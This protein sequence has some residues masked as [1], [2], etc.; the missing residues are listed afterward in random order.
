MIKPAISIYLV[1]LINEKGEN[2]YPKYKQ[3]LYI[4][5]REINDTIVERELNPELETVTNLS[6]LLHEMNNV[7]WILKNFQNCIH[8]Y[9]KKNRVGKLIA[10]LNMEDSDYLLKSNIPFTIA[11]LE[12][13]ILAKNSHI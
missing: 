13:Y 8:L 4:Q 10:E 5:L 6:I 12:E 11:K 7:C 2:L 3:S 1:E 9:S